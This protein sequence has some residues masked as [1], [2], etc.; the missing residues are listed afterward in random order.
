LA[1]DASECQIIIGRVLYFKTKT[2]GPHN[3]GALRAVHQIPD[4]LTD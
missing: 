3:A 2:K 4:E 1:L